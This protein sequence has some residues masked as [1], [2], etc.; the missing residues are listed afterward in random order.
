MTSHLL[1][2]R[3]SSHHQPFFFSF[4]NGFTPSLHPFR[5]LRRLLAPPNHPPPSLSLTHLPSCVEQGTIHKWNGAAGLRQ[6]FTPEV[7]SIFKG[8]V[9]FSPVGNFNPS[10]TLCPCQKINSKVSGLSSVSLGSFRFRVQLGLLL[11][12]QHPFRCREIRR[13]SL[14]VLYPLS[15]GVSCSSIRLLG[16]YVPSSGEKPN[17]ICILLTITCQM[18]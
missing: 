18:K 8:S 11:P 16:R 12:E 4:Q 5:S 14:S 6:C 10:E 2:S 13:A 3:L 9:V 17:A 7:F 15:R 1:T